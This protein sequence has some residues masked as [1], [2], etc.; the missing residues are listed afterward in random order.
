MISFPKQNLWKKKIITTI[1]RVVINSYFYSAMNGV[2]S[3]LW[4][5]NDKQYSNHVSLTF[6]VK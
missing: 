3:L 2:N 5:A 1:V 4:P 6:E